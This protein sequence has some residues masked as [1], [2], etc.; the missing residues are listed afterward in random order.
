[1]LE[2]RKRKFSPINSLGKIRMRWTI[3]EL[4]NLIPMVDRE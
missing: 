2:I 4:K 1:M 3:S